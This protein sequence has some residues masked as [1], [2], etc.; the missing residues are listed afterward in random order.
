MNTHQPKNLNKKSQ[1]SLAKLLQHEKIGISICTS[2]TVFSA[3]VFVFFL[4]KPSSTQPLYLAIACIFLLMS[5][6]F[7]Y[8]HRFIKRIDIENMSTDLI[9]TQCR[10]FKTFV[11]REKTII[12]CS[13]GFLL[14]GIHSGWFDAF[15]CWD[16]KR[17][18]YIIAS[19]V[20]SL[21]LVVILS[22]YYRFTYNTY[23]KN[24]EKAV[25]DL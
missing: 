8:K 5:A 10:K 6:W 14:A 12:Y 9:L 11:N 1:P 16:T 13:M 18:E 19:V 7:Y 17:I 22:L 3:V 2:I 23:F 25:A 4:L 21:L 15:L 24:F 20:V